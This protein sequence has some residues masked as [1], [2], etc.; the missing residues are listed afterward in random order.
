M[1]G[2]PHKLV[3]RRTLSKKVRSLAERAQQSIN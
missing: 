3:P 1:T 2:H